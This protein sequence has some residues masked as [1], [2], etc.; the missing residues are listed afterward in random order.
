MMIEQDEMLRLSTKTKI[1][2]QV[3]RNHHQSERDTEKKKKKKEK[4]KKKGEKGEFER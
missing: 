1:N 4:K 2:D 3:D